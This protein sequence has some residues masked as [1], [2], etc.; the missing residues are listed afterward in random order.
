MATQE[1]RMDKPNGIRPEL[2][3]E[4][5]V[6]VSTQE[7]LFGAEGLLKQ[8]TGKLVE[9]A[10]KAELDHH[11]E[12]DGEAS[13]RSNGTSAKTL[14]T[15]HGPVGIDVARD[16]AGTFEPLLLPK[17]QKRI[18]GLDD[19]ILS[20]YA[21]GMSVRD[22][23]AH[24]AELYGTEISPELISRVT[25]AVRDEIVAWQSRPVEPTYAVVW[26]DAL[27]VKIRDGGVVQNKAAYV[28][29]GMRL[30][31][32]KELL[33]LW[34]E[35]TEG[36]KF[37]QR[38]LGELQ[39][40]G[41]RD[42]LIACC[43]GLKG[44]PQ[45]IGAVFPQ[46]VVQTCIV[47]QVRYSLSFVTWKDRKPL[48]AGLKRIY[49]APTEDA[50]LGALDE[51][52]VAWATRYPMIADSWRRNW[53]QIRPFLELPPALRKMVYTTNSVESL[54][55]QLRKVIKTK[56]H[57]PSDEAAYKLL[58]LALRNVERNWQ[59]R[60]CPEWRQIYAQLVNRFGTRAEQKD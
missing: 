24:L 8:L 51:L 60:A 20:L 9:R 14:L 33:G 4:L 45:A 39:A 40:R 48:V 31:G 42:V 18:K 16:R 7:D 2:L 53:E 56:G 28:A 11:L 26:L 55:Y 10:L 35:L 13:N 5:L 23:Q 43:D 15:E 57:F 44:L 25:E 34:I 29:I 3:D 49:T 46:T 12:Q 27:M 59:S 52:A 6:G 54:N 22:I 32:S 17:H 47:H 30:D 19:K 58:Y 41:L 38:V 50:A 1:M 37:W 36:A 21:R